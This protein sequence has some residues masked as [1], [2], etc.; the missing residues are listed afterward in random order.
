MRYEDVH[1][2]RAE[3]LYAERAR[4]LTAA[5]AANPEAI[6]AACAQTAQ[7][8]D[9]RLDQQTH[10]TGGCSLITIADRLIRVDRLRPRLEYGNNP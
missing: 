3:T 5:Y 6:R 2:G 7:A 4:V 1:S 8:A 9:R 10:H